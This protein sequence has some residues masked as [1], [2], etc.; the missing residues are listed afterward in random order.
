[1]AIT[2]GVSVVVAGTE[3]TVAA[4][5]ATVDAV[6][7]EEVTEVEK[8]GIEAGEEVEDHEEAS[9][10]EVRYQHNSRLSISALSS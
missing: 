10:G 2:V 7:S 1:M 6:G 9:V 8:V 5:G 3:A 4:R